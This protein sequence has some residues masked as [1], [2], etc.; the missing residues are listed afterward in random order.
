M[1][2]M[3]VAKGV[4]G[5]AGSGRDQTKTALDF[6]TSVLR[7]SRLAASGCV[8]REISSG[9]AV[10]VSQCRFD[11]N[12][13]IA[14]YRRNSAIQWAFYRMAPIL[15]PNRRGMQPRDGTWIIKTG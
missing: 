14:I 15:M 3:S 5:R 10:L 1:M 12:K 2:G 11:C 4:E 13:S 9:P 7:R 6:A 8:Q